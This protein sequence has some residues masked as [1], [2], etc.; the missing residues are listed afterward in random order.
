MFFIEST[1]FGI[2]GNS[3]SISELKETFFLYR[4]AGTKEISAS[5]GDFAEYNLNLSDLKQMVDWQAS[6]GAN[7]FHLN[8]FYYSLSNIDIE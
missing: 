3:K 2:V 8:A 4:Q 6:L 5:I 7:H 1:D